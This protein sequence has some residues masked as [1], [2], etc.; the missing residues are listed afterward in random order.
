M[1]SIHTIT[2]DTVI[3]NKG[4]INEINNNTDMS[5]IRTITVAPNEPEITNI[6]VS[7][8]VF[9]IPEPGVV[10]PI[11]SSNS[12]NSGNNVI[13]S[14]S[15]D[16]NIASKIQN[17]FIPIN[18][19]SSQSSES[20]FT[21]T[22]PNNSL[23]NIQQPNLLSSYINNNTNNNTNHPFSTPITTPVNMSSK[24]ITKP[25]ANSSSSSS[26]GVSVSANVKTNIIN[27]AKHDTNT[28]TSHRR[29]SKKRKIKINDD[30][31]L[32]DTRIDYDDD[33]EEIK[34]IKTS[35]F[36]FV[37][38][39]AF[40]LIL[41]IPYLRS[42]LKPILNNP[43]LAYNE[44]EKQFEDF[45]DELNA[46][47]LGNIKKYV[48]V[49][50]IRDKLNYIL[51]IS[52]KKIMDDGKIDINDAP[53]FIQLVYFIIHAFNE[54]ND[55]EIYKFP[56]SKEHVMLLLHFI[57]KSVFCLTLDGEEEVM[58]VG[59]LDTSFK[60]VRIE[61]CPLASRKWYDVFRKFFGCFRKKKSLEDI[62]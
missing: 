2:A 47:E 18:V 5:I 26:T 22:V 55:G 30:E 23:I 46:T 13:L 28:V 6:D 42:K 7:D 25:S 19:L 61:V 44:I 16:N 31:E 32:K 56:V 12:S 45:K 21:A 52:F 33:D 3:S 4:V 24:V 49:E 37:K 20:A 36:N 29:V 17:A 11:I 1:S 58:A 10:N 53:Q 62:Q 35:L 48:C 40:N 27:N 15:E 34:K 50:G 54:I 43:A 60:L 8:F 41:T 57:L 51:D 9:D 39:I 14:I 59:L 38:D